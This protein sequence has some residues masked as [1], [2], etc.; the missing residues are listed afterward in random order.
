[1]R[2]TKPES[3]PKAKPTELRLLTTEELRTAVGGDGG[4]K[5]IITQ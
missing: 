4:T 3:E 5:I 1:M 2:K